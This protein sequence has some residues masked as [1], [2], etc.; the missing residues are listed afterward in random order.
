VGPELPN[1]AA[2]KIASGLHRADASAPCVPLAVDAPHQPVFSRPAIPQPREVHPPRCSPGAATRASTATPPR[3]FQSL[4]TRPSTLP[5]NTLHSNFSNA[6][7]YR[8]PRPRPNEQRASEARFGAGATEPSASDQRH[9]APVSPAGANPRPR[10]GAG[11]HPNAHQAPQRE[12]APP[13]DLA[14]SK[15]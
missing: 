1:H 11:V 8:E 14:P 3:P 12:R 15:A 7:C 6:Q 2:L 10:T 13:R 4:T 5:P 9:H